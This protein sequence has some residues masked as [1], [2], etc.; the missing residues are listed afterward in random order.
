MALQDIAKLSRF[1]ALAMFGV[2]I[3]VF[4]TIIRGQQVEPP[5]DRGD[6]YNFFAPGVAQAVG[7]MAFA[8]V[9]H[10]N[11][12]LIY[13]S[14]VDTSM[15]RCGRVSPASYGVRPLPPPASHFSL[16]SPFPSPT[17]TGP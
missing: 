3:I 7:I 14:L 8:Y 4:V 12:F 5:P 10:H 1:S 16:S 9:C 17:S 11:S 2:I 6:P 15:K 13:E